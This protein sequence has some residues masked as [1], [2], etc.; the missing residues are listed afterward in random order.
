[1]DA[2]VKKASILKFHRAYNSVGSTESGYLTSLDSTPKRD[3]FCSLSLPNRISLSSST[4]AKRADKYPLATGKE[5]NRTFFFLA[6]HVTQRRD[7]GDTSIP[8]DRLES[9]LHFIGAKVDR[10]ELEKISGEHQLQVCGVSSWVSMKTGTTHLN[11]AE[12]TFIISNL[13][14]YIFLTINDGCAMNR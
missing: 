8:R 5:R 12:R 11:A 7:R 2:I 14:S 9:K 1:V 6:E 4:N 3:L 13:A 10:R